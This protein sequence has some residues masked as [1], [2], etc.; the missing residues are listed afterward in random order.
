MDES[1]IDKLGVAIMVI[2]SMRLRFAQDSN[3]DRHEIV[4]LREALESCV[5]ALEYEEACI[6]EACQAAA[7][8]ASD[9]NKSEKV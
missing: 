6:D 5:E 2:E 1:L 7:A 3:L 9:K 8:H 4:E